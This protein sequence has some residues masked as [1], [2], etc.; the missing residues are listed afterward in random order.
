[1]ITTLSVYYFFFVGTFNKYTSVPI[2]DLIYLSDFKMQ[3]PAR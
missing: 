3:Y 2:S 1:M